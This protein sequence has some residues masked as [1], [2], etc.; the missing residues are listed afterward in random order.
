MLSKAR[1]REKMNEEHNKCLLELLISFQ[2]LKKGFKERMAALAEK[3]P[4]RSGKY[5][6][7]V[8]RKAA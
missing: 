3:S 5:K 2:N 8:R 4:T 6:K 1:Q 7:A